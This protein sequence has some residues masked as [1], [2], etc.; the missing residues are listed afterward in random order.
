MPQVQEDDANEFI[1]KLD[2]A[3]PH[4]NN[5]VVT[6]V[7]ENLRNRWI[8]RSSADDLHLHHWLPWSPDLTPIDFF[9]W[10]FVKDKVFVLPLPKNLGELR[11]CITTAINKVY[12]EML[13]SVW[14]ELDF[15]IM[16]DGHIEDL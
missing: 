6:S 9:L 10:G 1:L 15:R 3:P 16:R 8:R 4:F 14:S 5:I 7:N 12:R 11:A 13:Q 2:G